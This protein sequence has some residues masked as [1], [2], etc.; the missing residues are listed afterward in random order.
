MAQIS[1]GPT[2]NGFDAFDEDE[3]EEA[4][5]N[6]T[7]FNVKPAALCCSK[8]MFGQQGFAGFDK[9]GRGNRQKRWSGTFIAETPEGSNKFELGN[10]TMRWQAEIERWK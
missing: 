10:L 1:L 4:D 3:E 6:T 5:K 2:C 8:E 7:G 9:E